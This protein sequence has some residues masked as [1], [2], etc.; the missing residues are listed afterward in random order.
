ME[1]FLSIV[2]MSN[3]SIIIDNFN[4]EFIDDKFLHGILCF[5]SDKSISVLSTGTDCIRIFFF[6]E[7][8]ATYFFHKTLIKTSPLS[9]NIVCLILLTKVP[10]EIV[11]GD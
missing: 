3:F 6:S 7:Y 8:S 9:E 11:H 4:D 5:I 10:W 2:M 1:H